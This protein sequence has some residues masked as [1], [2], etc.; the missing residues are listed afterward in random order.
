MFR[1]VAKVA[2]IVRLSWN[3]Y[4]LIFTLELF[5]LKNGSASKKYLCICTQKSVF[6][7]WNQFN[8][9]RNLFFIEKT[10]KKVT[11]PLEFTDFC[12]HEKKRILQ[13][14]NITAFIAVL[15][16]NYLSNTGMMNN[17]TIGEVSAQVNTLFTPAPYAFAIW[18]LIYLFLLATE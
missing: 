9:N 6:I 4:S 2:L 13:I 18:G 7:G 10:D 16:V 1:N 3:R 14:L 17:T 11:L 15:L 5:I 12:Y 8:I